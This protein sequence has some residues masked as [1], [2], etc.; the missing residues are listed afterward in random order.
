MRVLLELTR[1]IFLFAILGGLAWTFISGLYTVTEITEKYQWLGAIAIYVLLFVL[2][3]N[4]LQFSGW[5]RGKGRNK[6][7]KVMSRTLIFSSI[8]LMEL[9][10]IVNY[11]VL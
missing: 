4:R 5:Y 1:I 6:L 7:P 3:R 11:L 9:P 2:Y 8:L 10:F